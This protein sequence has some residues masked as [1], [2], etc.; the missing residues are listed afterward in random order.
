MRLTRLSREAVEAGQGQ[1][2]E[3]TFI[4]KS[5]RKTTGASKAKASKPRK[6]SENGKSRSQRDSVLDAE[7][8]KRKRKRMASLEEEEVSEDEIEAPGEF[9]DFI[10][11]DDEPLSPNPKR[12]EKRPQTVSLLDS[13][14]GL[15]DDNDIWTFNLDDPPPKRRRKAPPTG[16]G[17]HDEVVVISD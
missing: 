14:P 13:S 15:P 16:P 8:S 10:V 2:I 9:D 3:S 6:S 7:G 4:K 11:D 5:G 17:I 12:G 1:R